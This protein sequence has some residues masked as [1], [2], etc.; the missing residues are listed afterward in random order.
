MAAAVGFEAGVCFEVGPADAGRPARLARGRGCAI[1][2]TA[3]VMIRTKIQREVRF[4]NC[5]FLVASQV[6]QPAQMYRI[7]S[8]PTWRRFGS[9]PFVATSPKRRRAL[10]AAALQIRARSRDKLLHCLQCVDLGGHL[11]AAK[12]Y[13]AR[14]AQSVAKATM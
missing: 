1:A 4:M 7:W 12:S 8:A 3:T 5:I 11:V 2:L 13:D 10:L 9:L 6:C 14:K